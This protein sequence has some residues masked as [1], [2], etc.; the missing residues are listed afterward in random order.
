MTFNGVINNMSD[1]LG[2]Y[3]NLTVWSQNRF[4]PG[5][6]IYE[7]GRQIS[8]VINGRDPGT[9]LFATFDPPLPVRAGYS[10]GLL[11]PASGTLLV[12]PKFLDFGEGGAT[13]S[14]YTTFDATSIT[15]GQ[16]LGA[17]VNNRYLPLIR[18]VMEGE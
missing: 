8:S 14:F 13:D 10:T 5:T 15:T 11:Y 3:P 18:P 2:V 16:E 1:D 17:T 4:V 12:Q 7:A 9:L 6:Y